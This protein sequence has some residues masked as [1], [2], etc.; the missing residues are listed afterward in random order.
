[1]NKDNT[2]QEM[3]EWKEICHKL[4]LR[5]ETVDGTDEQAMI[6]NHYL[7]WFT[8]KTN[9]KD[10]TV[11]EII[12]NICKRD[13]YSDAEANDVLAVFYSEPAIVEALIT[14]GEQ[15]RREEQEIAA[16]IM[17]LILPFAKGYVA[18]ND[19]GANRRYLEIAENYIDKL[20]AL[21]D[22]RDTK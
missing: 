5:D 7:K 18:E 16:K 6:R 3:A 9:N 8:P 1:M 22:K 13:G 20:Q 17:W 15:V 2:E 12:L 19:K 14:Y 21:S 10:N 11:E 4:H